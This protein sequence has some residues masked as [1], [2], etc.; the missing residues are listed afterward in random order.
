M[1]IKEL[2]NS[3]RAHVLVLPHNAQGHIN[4]S[5]QFAKRLASKGLKVTVATTIDIKHNQTEIDS[6]RVEPICNLDEHVADLYDTNAYLGCVQTVF[7]RALAE[8][9]ERHEN[10]GDPFCCLIYDSILPWCLDIA[11]R[12]GLFGAPF[13][14]QPCGIG[15]I[16]YYVQKGELSVP[17][18]VSTVSLPGLPKFELSDLPSFVSDSVSYP[19][20][21]ELFSNQFSN[22]EKVDWVLIN[23]FETLEPELVS[24]MKGLWPVK[25]IGPSVP[26]MYVDKL[27]KDDKNYGLSF[28]A[29][30]GA[31]CLKWLDT[32]P[33]RSVVYASM[34]SI[35]EL[36]LEHMEEMAWGLRRSNN[37]FLWVVRE[38]EKK[39]LPSNFIEETIEKG[40]IMNWCPQLE[41]LAHEAVGCFV[42][43]CGWNSTV[44]A[45]S[46]GVPMVA[47]PQWADQP[48]N[49]KYVED[50]WGVGVRA[51]A[52]EKGIVRRE[53]IELCIREVMEGE[54]GKEIRKNAGKWRE[55]AIEALDVGGSSI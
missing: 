20:C 6:I 33:T 37:Y 27:I 17:L 44:E 28:W 32:K 30:D 47:M 23:T 31:T 43:H 14:T 25:T 18:E 12:F 52:D 38:A 54:R 21:L 50:V 51:K 13:F 10:S 26:S 4:P 1:E 22:L 41:V 42:T 48:T 3:H 29:P 5:I 45:L 35:A 2:A 49:A 36:G 24:W 7:S 8:C 15:T 11:K 53:E 19:G 46:I 16:F 55:L 39:K 40:L 9:I 34:G